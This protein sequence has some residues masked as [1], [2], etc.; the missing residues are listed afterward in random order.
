[1]AR[2]YELKRS[3]QMSIEQMRDQQ[4]TKALGQAVDRHQWTVRETSE[5]VGGTGKGA[6]RSL[7]VALLREK[8]NNAP[9]SRQVSSQMKSIQRWLAN[10][11]G[12]GAQK[13]RPSPAAR[14]LLNRVG[15]NR[16]LANR[17]FSVKLEGEI[18][19]NSYRRN[20]KSFV[21]FTKDKIDLALSFLESP[22]YQDLGRAY[23]K[24]EDSLYGFGDDLSV[25]IVT[26]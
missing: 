24:N 8:G 15:R 21:D 4:N 25:E 7:A 16:D 3:V 22:N 6:N 13:S 10:E 23:L 12:S 20:R 1:M 2:T 9:T 18:A 26:G 14:A 11:K 17:G 5:Y 19:V